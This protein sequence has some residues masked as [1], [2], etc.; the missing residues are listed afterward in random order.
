MMY[1][2][3]PIFNERFFISG[4]LNDGHLNTWLCIAMTV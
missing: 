2:K 4:A 3:A 1:K